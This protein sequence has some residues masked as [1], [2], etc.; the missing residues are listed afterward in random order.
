MN[1]LT[2]PLVGYKNLLVFTAYYFSVLLLI[3]TFAAPWKRYSWK[4]SKRGI[5]PTEILY[6]A[7]SNIVAR[8]IGIVARTVMILIGL[9]GLLGMV[10]LGFPLAFFITFLDPYSHIF[11]LPHL[12]KVRALAYDWHYGFTPTLDPYVQDLYEHI[13]K[14]PLVDRKDERA[15]I[16]RALFQDNGGHVLL[17]GEPGSGRHVLL[18]SIAHVIVNTRFLVFDYV[19]F[20]KDKK[21]EEEKEGALEELLDEVSRAGNI[22]FIFDHFEH[23]LPYSHLLEQYL[24][25]PDFHVIGITNPNTYN[26]EI[27]PDKTMMKYFEAVTIAQLSRAY[28]REALEERAHATSLK[29]EGSV[30]DTLLNASYQLI[31]TESKHQPEAAILLFDEFASYYEQHKKEHDI[32]AILATFL[33]HRLKIPFAVITERD[34]RKL[35]NL[36]HYLE[37]FVVGQPQAISEISHALKRRRLNLSTETKPIGSFLFL[38]PTGVGKT[39]TAKA[40]TRI[41]FE[42]SKKLLRFDMASYQNQS[43]VMELVDALAQKIRET[44]YGVLLLDEFEKAHHDLI[45]VF[46]TILDEGYFHDSHHNQVLCNNL[47]IIA[48]SNAG[49]EFIRERLQHDVAAGPW[50]ANNSATNT[51][52]RQEPAATKTIIDYILTNSIFSPE[53]I[54]RFDAV[55]AFSPLSDETIHSII[56]I[57]LDSLN[58]RLIKVNNEP[59]AISVE[60]INQIA[61]E[62]SQAEFGGREIDRAIKRLVEDT[63]AEKLLSDDLVAS[64]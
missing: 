2:K 40:L 20:M 38:G 3:S 45:N 49:S 23:I 25:K 31:S 35:K 54:N 12:L 4:K 6:V 59:V 21:L 58:R 63:L 9:C 7:V 14:F 60:L 62:G 34:K 46:L 27:L 29:L 1:L 50:P 30:F 47:I 51:E 17:I 13:L 22:V 32:E 5:H 11:N 57:K 37:Q 24:E 33:E 56:K 16:S 10:I 48:T 53:L 15:T 43:Q 26:E 61:A 64:G 52:A 8:V 19:A 39:Q 41:F 42:D 55:V 44:P 28:V 36:E 18:A